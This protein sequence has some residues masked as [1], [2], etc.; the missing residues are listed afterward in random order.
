MHDHEAAMAGELAVAFGGDPICGVGIARIRDLLLVLVL[1]IV[2]RCDLFSQ[3]GVEIFL[4]VIRVIV[5]FLV[6][7]VVLTGRRTSCRHDGFGVGFAVDIHRVLDDTDDVANE[8]LLNEIAVDLEIVG[9]EV[10][11]EVLVRLFCIEFGSDFFALKLFVDVFIHGQA[12][13]PLVV[14]RAES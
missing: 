7:F 4:N 6:G 12:L 1:E 8:Y 14:V 11:V 5:L 9:S 13:A 2:T 10:L 3:D